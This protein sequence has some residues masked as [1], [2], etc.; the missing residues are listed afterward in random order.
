MRALTSH[1]CGVFSISGPGMTIMWVE[2]VAGSHPC[3]KGFSLG[4]LVFLSPQKSTLLNSN[5]I[6]KQRMKSH[7][8]VMPL[9][10]LI[11]IVIITGQFWGNCLIS[12]TLIGSFLSSIRVLM[13]KIL[14]YASSQQLNVQL[15]KCQL[16]NQWDFVDPLK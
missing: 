12:C 4:S 11:I 15:S 3:S 14:I 1:Q 13:D 6:W 2:F 5:L 16:F 7:F 10:I 8:V 9:Q